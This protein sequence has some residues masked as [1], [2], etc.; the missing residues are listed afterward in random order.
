M[1][2]H[3]GIL[4]AATLGLCPMNAGAQSPNAQSANAGGPNAGTERREEP[5]RV[6]VNINLFFPGPTGESEEAAKLRERVRR[7][8]YEMA[9]SECA[10]VEQVLAKNCRLES[11]NMNINR[12]AGTPGGQGEGYNAGGS[13][14]LRVVPK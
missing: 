2:R 7:A 14:T 4:L 8:V 13:I 9:G 5:I 1:R 10:V 12:Q 3:I 11:I 6:T